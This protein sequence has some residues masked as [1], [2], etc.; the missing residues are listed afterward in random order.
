MKCVRVTGTDMYGKQWA[1]GSADR[2]RAVVEGYCLSVFG[3]NCLELQVLDGLIS[4]VGDSNTQRKYIS[5]YQSA[6]IDF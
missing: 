2:F 5:I 1:W 4:E 3:V 6:W